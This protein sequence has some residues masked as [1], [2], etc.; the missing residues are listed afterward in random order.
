MPVRE[1]AAR[2]EIS[3]SFVDAIVIAGKLHGSRRRL[4]S[5]TWPISDDQLQL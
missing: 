5:G 4:G 2:L 3:P 1:S